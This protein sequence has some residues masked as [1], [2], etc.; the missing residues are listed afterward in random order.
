MKLVGAVP[1]EG[2]RR[3]CGWLG[4]Q[5]TGGLFVTEVSTGDA[6]AA[7]AA[8]GDRVCVQ[9]CGR[10]RSRTARSERGTH[11]AR[12]VGFCALR[13]SR[14][15]ARLRG[16]PLCESVEARSVRPLLGFPF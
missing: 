16:P 3:R 5:G 7:A 14:Q 6:A 8:A 2:P 13:K 10:R 11:G 1:G 12:A 9:N 4:P 15:G